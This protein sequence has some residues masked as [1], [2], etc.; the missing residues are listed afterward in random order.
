[1]TPQDME[2][3]VR[4][5]INEAFES[6]RSIE[7]ETHAKHHAWLDRQIAKD[8]ERLALYKVLREQA[9]TFLMLGLLTGLLVRVI[10]GHWPTTWF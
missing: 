3:I 5:V 6:R 8:E 7:A 9:S 1:M 2:E 4:H 10:T